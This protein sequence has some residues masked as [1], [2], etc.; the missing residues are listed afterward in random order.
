MKK[1][2]KKRHED[3]FFVNLQEFL[4]DFTMCLFLHEQLHNHLGTISN[5]SARAKNSC[6]TCFVQEVVILC[7]DDTT[8]GDHDV[9]S[10]EFLEFLDDLRDKCLVTSCQRGD[11]QHMDVVLDGLFGCLSSEA[12]IHD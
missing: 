10:A 3:A 5:G 11:T 1:I 9:G 7:G 4:V 6:N 8:G 12:A 2:Q